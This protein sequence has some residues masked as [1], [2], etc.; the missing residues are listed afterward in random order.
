ME[1]CL[2]VPARRLFVCLVVLTAV[3]V[4]WFVPAGAAPGRMELAS[5]WRTR[6]IR[7]D[8][9]DEEW[10]DLTVPVT[11]QHFAVGFVNDDEAL[12]FCLVTKERVSATQIDR[13]GLEFLVGPPG[14]RTLPNGVRFPVLAL[15]DGRRPG[16]PEI[17]VLG[18]GKRDTRREVLDGRDGL[19][20]AMAVRG[21][22]LVYELRIPLHA[23]VPGGFAI[24][25]DPGQT[26]GIEL[27]TPDWKG[28]LPPA[29]GIGGSGIAIGV[30]PTRPR[31]GGWQG[32]YAGPPVDAALLKPLVVGADL[33]LAS[34]PR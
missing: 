29:P 19:A 20:A 28:P 7:V 1:V 30:T 2:A 31:G 16:E 14:G 12:Y 15:K 6:D 13:M 34:A 23:V 18:P 8:G 33:H 32:G 21:D 27:R 26:L 5:V 24:T 9:L 22:L 17:E 3:A 25:A 4:T 10:R 11:G